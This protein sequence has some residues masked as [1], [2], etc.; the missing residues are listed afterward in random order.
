MKKNVLLFSIALLLLCVV[1]SVACADE[2]TYRSDN[3]I[4]S[5][6]EGGTVEIVQYTGSESSFDIPDEIEN[7]KVTRIGDNAFKNNEKLRYVDMG[8]NIV[9][10]GSSAFE[11]CTSLKS[12]YDIR[13]SSILY[14]GDCAF[15][16]CTALTSIDIPRDLSEIEASTFE[17]CTS[18]RKVYYLHNSSVTSIGE[19]AF[20]KCI[21]LEEIDIPLY[22]TIISESAFEKCT[23]LEKI[24]YMRSSAVT[25]IEKYAFKGCLRLKELES[26]MYLLEIGESAFE[27]CKKL[28]EIKY[29]NESDVTFGV[30]AFANCPKMEYIPKK[31]VIDESKISAID[32]IE[33]DAF[34]SFIDSSA[35]S[36]NAMIFGSWHSTGQM[37][38]NVEFD[39]PDYNTIYNLIIEADGTAYASRNNNKMEIG[40]WERSGS[41]LDVEFER[42]GEFV[43]WIT[44]RNIIMQDDDI[45]IIFTSDNASDPVIPQ[46]VEAKDDRQFNGD[47]KLSRVYSEYCNL[48]S[49]SLYNLGID[50]SYCIHIT[51]DVAEVTKRK[52][53]NIPIT[54]KKYLLN[55]NLVITNKNRGTS[56]QLTL[57]DTGE[58]VFPMYERGS[59]LY[60]CFTNASADAGQAFVLPEYSDNRIHYILEKDLSISIPTEIISVNREVDSS[61][62]FYHKGYADY[63]SL[64]SVMESENIYLYGVTEDRQVE[65]TLRVFDY[66]DEDFNTVDD[67]LLSTYQEQF[68]VSLGWAAKDVKADIY[69]GVMNK[70]IRIRYSLETLFAGDQYIVLYYTTHGDNLLKIQFL[71]YGNKITV[72]QENMVQDIFDSIEWLDKK[73]QILV[74]DQASGLSYRIPSYWKED[75]DEI[76]KLPVRYR[77]GSDNAWVSY[78]REDLWK[79]YYDSNSET[80]EI[81]GINRSNYF[82]Y[83][84]LEVI[85]AQQLD[86]DD[87][88]IFSK[89][90]ANKKYYFIN[91]GMRSNQ[92]IMYFYFSDGYMYKYWLSGSNASKYIDELEQFLMT[93]E[94][95]D[96][97][98]DQSDVE[99]KAYQRNESEIFTL[100]QG[101]YQVGI[102]INPGIYYVRRV[103]PSD[104]ESG[105]LYLYSQYP[106]NFNRNVILKESFELGGSQK[107]IAIIEKGEYVKIDNGDLTFSLSSIPD[108]YYH[109][110]IPEG[111]FMP[112]GWYIVGEDIPAGLYN[113]YSGS[114]Y[115]GYLSVYAEG[116][117]PNDWGKY[118]HSVNCQEG[119]VVKANNPEGETIIL[120]D[121]KVICVDTEIVLRK[122]RDLTDEEKIEQSSDFEW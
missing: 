92:E 85:A 87:Y 74:T 14:I 47:W 30:N 95:E 96:L 21:S 120:R 1:F 119:K 61:D 27:G 75:N 33:T 2:R 15:K 58:M 110:E 17:E 35:L 51:D 4:Y 32:E 104:Y 26:P 38:N 105:Y 39:L 34:P 83:N 53:D 37:I 52:E 25:V 7:Y 65:F 116:T 24:Y 18:L 31:A 109:Y 102:D 66:S 103:I 56:I 106:S 88:M 71:S 50:E 108:D 78:E 77:I 9:S 86:C 44:D 5:I 100:A 59:V 63:T 70:A 97:S 3:F 43:F 101:V 73:E 114:I 60:V 42:S 79:N 76:T 40:S 81:Y 54:Y 19:R 107:Q 46:S 98:G 23:H 68:K 29:L 10:I 28:T 8:S 72:E 16:G 90:I 121:S 122:I 93:V 89:P 112:V 49:S 48:S 113:V 69:Q 111:T 117:E 55:G 80:A 84:R 62:S 94:Y 6:S 13:S 11:G 41:E 67:A 57:T 99:N 91:E 82:D 115:D 45:G 20:F 36:K 118:I 12:I 64:Q 22:A